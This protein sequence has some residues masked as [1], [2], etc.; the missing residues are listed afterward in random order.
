MRSTFLLSAVAVLAFGGCGDHGLPPPDFGPVDLSVV[1]TDLAVDLDMGIPDDAKKVVTFTQFAQDYAQALCAHYMACGELDTAQMAAC[2]ENNL[3]HTGWDQDVEINKGRVE[4]NELQCLAAVQTARCDFSDIGAWSSRCE[5]FL[6]TGH[7]ANGGACVA[8]VECTSGFCQHGGSDAGIEQV[9]G[10]P[11]TCATPKATGAACRLD[12][13]CASD[14][15]C[16]PMNGCTKLAPLN[17][18]CTNSIGAGTGQN[19]Q[20]GLMCPTFA[21]SPTCVVP[22]TQTTLHGA[23]DPYQGSYS[24]TPACSASMYCQLH[25]TQDAASTCTMDTDCPFSYCDTAAGK[26]MTA[27]S[28]TCENKLAAGV[29][30]D[31]HNTG[32]TTFVNEQCADKSL[33]LQ[34]GTQTKATCQSFGADAADCNQ[35]T[36]CKIGFF[37]NGGKCAALTADGQMCDPSFAHCASETEQ[38]VCIADNA[39][40]GMN[41]TCEVTKNF[42]AP[43][44]PGFED[45]LC[46]PADLPGDPTKP[47]SGS[48]Y[49]APNGSGGGTCAPKC[50]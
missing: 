46:A 42:G 6:Y 29:D 8:D 1:V 45:F 7:V 22:A 20:F 13:D 10:C 2:L 18:P 25:Y 38:T 32:T 30:C 3:H 49:C 15:F 16:D 28:G 47:G 44:N 40:A 19:C 35:D 27:T 14:S 9:T 50:F 33:C 41:T 5:Q 31:P 26:C 12:T 17:Q 4:V 39:D 21:T 23:C 37:C 43:C 34:A 36:D 48:S 11:G 24:P